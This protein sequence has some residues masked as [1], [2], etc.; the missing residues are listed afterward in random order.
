MGEVEEAKK[1]N[2]GDFSAIMSC[3]IHTIRS[4]NSISYTQ[5]HADSK[6]CRF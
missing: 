4:F 5:Y 3:S 2:R 6:K 1:N